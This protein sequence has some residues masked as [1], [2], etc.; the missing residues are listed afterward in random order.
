MDAMRH[1]VWIALFGLTALLAGCSDI[2][3][4]LGLGR[5]PPDEFAV[6]DRPPLALPPDFD[7]RPPQPGAP[8]PQDESTNKRASTMLFG[9]GA[10]V[11]STPD[12]GFL[13]GNG[14]S[15]ASHSDAEKALLETAGAAKAETGIREKVD[16]EA[17]QKVVGTRHLVDELLW[18]RKTEA[19]ATT[20][21]AIAEA[22]R[23]QES[24]EKGEPVNQ[25][26]TPVIEKKKSGW[27]GM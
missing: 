16:R 27:L 26:A 9:P 5:N 14:T 13:A 23:L 10:Q 24:K 11:S 2:T 3:D 7:L 12:R 20:V 8:R 18:W 15:N 1:S 4:T 21:D 25:G 19:P 22:E 6:V 17:S